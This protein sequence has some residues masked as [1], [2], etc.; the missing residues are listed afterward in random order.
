[1]VPLT[2]KDYNMK[3][4]VKEH[5]KNP[6][7]KRDEYVVLVD[8]A[9]KPTPSRQEILK[10]LAKE[11]KVAEDVIIINKIFSLAGKQVSETRI[12]VYRKKGEIPA[13]K[14]EKMSRKGAAGE[15]KEEPAGGE[16][17]AE[18]KP[19][20]EEPKEE[21]VKAEEESSEEGESAPPAE[22][23]SKGE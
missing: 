5:R 21:D 9:G 22:P 1:M 7:M 23:P 18:E 10:E 15:T 14:L 19:A 20:A 2:E 12:H 13:D 8:H 4:D 16:K 6:L 11:L 17:P 3:I